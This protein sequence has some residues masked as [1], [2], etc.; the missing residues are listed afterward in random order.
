M[1]SYL[2]S[3]EK[4]NINKI[5]IF[6]LFFHSNLIQPSPF[7]IS[8][9][10][11]AWFEWFIDLN[12]LGLTK[13]SNLIDRRWRE[14]SRRSEFSFDRISLREIH[15]PFPPLP[16]SKAFHLQET[17]G[18]NIRVNWKFCCRPGGKRGEK[19]PF[20][21]GSLIIR[22]RKPRR[23]RSLPPFNCYG[24]TNRAPPLLL[25]QKYAMSAANDYVEVDE[26][27]E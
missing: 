22:N 7:Y 20:R 23:S 16:Y 25:Q 21:A 10:N 1:K 3:I 11:S 13:S 14:I 19:R 27:G 2:F 18:A 6:L 24:L 15:T 17:R 9:R 5:S 12:R 8:I 26:L 4:N